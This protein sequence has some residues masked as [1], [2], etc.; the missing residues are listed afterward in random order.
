ML[1]TQLIQDISNQKFRILRSKDA[2]SASLKPLPISSES[3]ARD[4]SQKLKPVPHNYWRNLVSGSSL[5]S[6]TAKLSEREINQLALKM[7]SNGQLK[8]YKVD[9]PDT[10]KVPVEN[11][12]VKNGS[13]TYRFASSS[14]LL[15]SRPREYK[16]FKDTKEAKAYLSK[17]GI[18]EK[19]AD[20]VSDGLSLKSTSPNANAYEAIVESLAS[21]EIIVIVDNTSSVPVDESSSS[22]QVHSEP[23]AGLGPEVEAAAYTSAVA[24][25]F[26]DDGKEEKPED[27]PPCT[28]D[29]VSLECS[30]GRNTG[31]TKETIA[32]PT[33]SVIAAETVE[34]DFDLIKASIHAGALCDSHKLDRF[35][36]TPEHN[37]KH[38]S[39]TEVEFKVNCSAWDMSNFFDRV[40]LPSISPKTYTLSIKDFCQVNDL[41]IFDLNIDVYP[42]IKWF[43]ETQ[44]NMGKLNFTP[45]KSKF[46]Y[47][48]FDITGDVTLTYDG[49]DYNA[50]EKYKKY[51]T[52]PL[53]TFK[54]ICDGIST[55]L[56]FINDPASLMRIGTETENPKPPEGE[57]NKDGNG[58]SLSIQW[59]KLDIGYNSEIKENGSG[60]YIDHDYTIS[61]K[62][63]PLLEVNIE[64][65]VLEVLMSFAPAPAKAIL[66]LAKRKI[67]KKLKE[68]E[69]SDFEGELDIRFK[70]NT[71][72]DIT[73]GELSGVHNIYDHDIS[74]K[75]IKSNIEIPVELIGVAKAKGRWL[76]I[77]FDIDYRIRGE[78]GWK[79][80]MEFGKD[81]N[82]IYMTQTMEFTG[83]II[84][85]TKYAEA[86]AE[87]EIE[88]E[89]SD[90]GD[91]FSDFGFEAEAS[92]DD[93]S[94]NISKDSE[95]TNID[96]STS[97]E[98][99]NTW[100]WIAEIKDEEKTQPQK[101]Y[102]LRN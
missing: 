37:V 13:A 54:K 74:G 19:Q 1:N 48:E 64:V 55:V 27:I 52:E 57:D 44:I 40:W 86:K 99:E 42:Q 38:K 11:L 68:N 67:E 78:A 8:A 39:A 98:S 96:L 32:P 60:S 21:G 95:G 25:D 61:I 79:G 47:S 14:T 16:E 51:I 91:A 31:I 85:L 49:E 65:D 73:E 6:N 53:D 23:Q 36:I 10:D 12:T 90:E 77:S 35:S 71:T 22:E 56:E 59:P 5:S 87:F 101:L 58:S 88:N 50:E 83:V 92:T 84:T 20:K 46:E 94:I 29:W 2:V 3:Q 70:V 41:K 9:Q 26:D 4:F 17:I 18:S 45:G 102:I 72:I 7:L 43:W 75:P 33:L 89:N 62:A 100:E 82:G 76:I 15:V 69:D 97:K 80:N 93:S 66:K 28:L 34:K 30:H 24:V 63:D 81:T